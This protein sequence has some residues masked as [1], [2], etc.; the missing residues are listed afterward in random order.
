MYCKNCGKELQDGAKVCPFC[1]EKIQEDEK[2]KG[3]RQAGSSRTVY[4]IGAG[5]GLAI[6]LVVFFIMRG[7]THESAR[8]AEEAALAVATA[9]QES[10][11]REAEEAALAVATAEQESSAREAE[12]TQESIQE[13][14][15]VQLETEHEETVEESSTEA[16]ERVVSYVKS[17]SLEGSKTYEYWYDEDGDFIREECD[18]FANDEYDYSLTMEYLRNENGNKIP[19]DKNRMETL[20][21]FFKYYGEWFPLLQNSG[22]L[23]YKAESSDGFFMENKYDG[24]NRLVESRI[25]DGI[26]TY[27]YEE[28]DGQTKVNG[29]FV[30]DDDLSSRWHPEHP[31][32]A[33]VTYDA[34]GCLT[35]YEVNTWLKAEEGYSAYGENFKEEGYSI[36]RQKFEYDSEG[37]VTQ[38]SEYLYDPGLDSE[39]EFVHEYTY[40]DKGNMIKDTSKHSYNNESSDESSDEYQYN[41]NGD[42]IQRDSYND[43]V[44]WEYDAKGRLTCKTD[45]FFS[46]GVGAPVIEFTYEYEYDD[47]NRPQ[48]VYFNAKEDDKTTA[49]K[50]GYRYD[51]QGRLTEILMDD[52]AVIK[53]SYAADGALTKLI[54]DRDVYEYSRW[55]SGLITN[56]LLEILPERMKEVYSPEFPNMGDRIGVDIA[57]VLA[58]T[59]IEYREEAE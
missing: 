26:V 29:T 5:L 6:V 32:Y 46:G 54:N 33:S 43:S 8:E 15:Q 17:V 39:S 24:Q 10:S 55:V 56:P 42:P 49:Y 12:Q 45:Y 59:T 47:G 22:Y 35:E 38:R 34:N 1:N 25:E 57:V 19:G 28:S 21:T 51:A 3:G 40:D 7:G 53:A 4:L 16:Q 13:T 50:V 30:C 58:D 31:D 11:T 48:T 37:K 2:D 44:I 20:L 9:E 41:E 27:T 52:K 14:T 36:Y 18:D 23:I